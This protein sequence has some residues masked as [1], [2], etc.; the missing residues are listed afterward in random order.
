M[1]LVSYVEKTGSGE[2]LLFT[3]KLL[4][5]DC[6]HAANSVYKRISMLESTYCASVSAVITSTDYDA[7]SVADFEQVIGAY[8][9]AEIDF[10]RAQLSALKSFDDGVRY[11]RIE[12][13]EP[14]KT[15]GAQWVAPLRVV[16]GWV[17]DVGIDSGESRSLDSWTQ[18]IDA[19]EQWI[20][21]EL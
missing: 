3:D 4:T 7:V 11:A 6:P 9:Q 18:A 2:S 1:F 10:S 8:K 15:A 13:R 17:E 12:E 14:C 20:G 21:G 16:F 19:C 5:Y